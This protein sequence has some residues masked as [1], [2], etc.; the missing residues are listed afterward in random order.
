MLN[1]EYLNDVV[2][3]GIKIIDSLQAINFLIINN[4]FGEHS[5]A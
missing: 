3:Y 2:A 4:L 1:D 5:E